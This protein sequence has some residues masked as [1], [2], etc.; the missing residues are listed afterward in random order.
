MVA[1]YRMS[2]D[3]DNEDCSNNNGKLI[4]KQNDDNDNINGS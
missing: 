4:S 1:L 3:N 2:V